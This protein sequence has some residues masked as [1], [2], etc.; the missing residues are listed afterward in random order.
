M[1]GC[2][3]TRGDMHHRAAELMTVLESGIAFRSVHIAG[4][5]EHFSLT[6]THIILNYIGS[7][8]DS[9]VPPWIGRILSLF[10]VLLR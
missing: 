2:D 8:A 4:A 7:G 1:T 10:V 5:G 6:T 3:V 9:G